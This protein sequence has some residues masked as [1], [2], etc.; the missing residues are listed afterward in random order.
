MRCQF[1]QSEYDENLTRCPNCGMRPEYVQTSDKSTKN[2]TTERK[3]IWHN[4]LI[5]F[6]IG[7]RK[8]GNI[9]GRASRSEYVCF[10]FTAFSLWIGL[11][12]GGVTLLGYQDRISDLPKG[13]TCA[14]AAVALVF[15]PAMVALIV[16]RLHDIGLSGWYF[17]VLCV[18]QYLLGSLD[19]N[20]F[21]SL[22][23][24]CLVVWPGSRA[25]NKFGKNP[26]F[27]D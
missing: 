5:W 19:L 3:K 24:L 10:M 25:E 7:M 1:C 14:F 21:T 2:E 16:R 18:I 22:L 12:F 8:W 9:K 6:L 17:W 4:P 15:V 11:F 26:R 20:V 23:P 13:A 27:L